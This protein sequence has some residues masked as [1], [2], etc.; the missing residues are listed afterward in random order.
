[1]TCH[2]CNLPA[3]ALITCVCSAQFCEACTIRHACSQRLWPWHQRGVE[4]LRE[5]IRSGLRSLVYTSPTGGGKTSVMSHL[6]QS[7]AAKDRSVLLLTNRKIITKQMRETID[8]TGVDYGV[9]AAGQQMNMGPSVQLARI[10]TINSRVYEREKFPLPPASL[11]LID[12][13]HSR[14]YDQVAEDYKKRGAVVV[15]FSATPV[16][17]KKGLYDRI[18]HAGTNTELVK[19]GALVPCE[20]FSVDEPDMQGVKRNKVGEFVH[21][22]MVRRVMQTIVFG[23]VFSHWLR[24]NPLQKPTM[25]FA[26]GVPESRWFVEQ[27]ESRGVRAAHIDGDTPEFEREKIIEG[28]R[29]GEIKV[30]SSFGVL[31]EGAN[32][33]W[34]VHGILVQVCGAFSTFL[35]LVGRLLRAHPGKEFAR[36]QDHS[37]AYHRH[38][39]PNQDH[40]WDLNDTDAKLSKERK[41]KLERGEEKEP[42]RCP[43]CG[44]I[45]PPG[46]QC[47]NCGH[48][49]SMSVRAVRMTDGTLQKKTG[50]VTKRKQRKSN[51]Q[52]AW[53]NCLYR[54]GRSG[55]TLKQAVGMYR[56]TTGT[57][58][59]DDVF[60]KPPPPES[61]D[62]GRKVGDIRGFEKFGKKRATQ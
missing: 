15:M 58:P 46:P 33:P 17:L 5:A 47:L 49:H 19:A 44:A 51:S 25:L 30:V 55:R 12:E 32:L 20:I 34:V 60:P 57:H 62:W 10:Q 2:G 26:P 45:R 7:A 59:P 43:E 53:T 9:I 61:L 48:R 24:L 41:K 6:A 54:A 4:E 31:R 28:S 23:D 29:N 37:G 16:G 35:Q 13:G 56:Q 18:I 52:M 42:V 27:F 1:M 40:V 14:L 3:A 50:S 36:L 21:K 8:E 22:G 39:D 11:V 38:P